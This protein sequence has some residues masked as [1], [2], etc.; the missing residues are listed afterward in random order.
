MINAFKWTNI[1]TVK[2][3]LTFE[4]IPVLFDVVVLNHDY[5]HIY[6]VD[7]LIEIRELV[8][9]DLVV[10]KEWIVAF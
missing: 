9:R 8:L 5:D 7:E 3:N 1:E 2:N 10:F 4:F 6:I